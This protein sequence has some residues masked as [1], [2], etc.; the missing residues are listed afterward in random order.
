MTLVER[1]LLVVR[2]TAVYVLS[3]IVARIENGK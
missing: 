3:V 1:M 2:A